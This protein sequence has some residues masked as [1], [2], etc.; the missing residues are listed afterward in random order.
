VR[1]VADQVGT[2][3]CTASLAAVCWA[4]GLRHRTA[5]I[6]HWTDAGVASWYDFAVAIAEDA[7]TAGLLRDKPAVAP[8]AT[9]DYPTPARRPAYSVLDCSATHA[10][11][12]L[13]AVHW[14]AR[15]RTVL[16]EMPHG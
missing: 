15:L 6:F 13:E 11:L 7:F 16:G 3:T 4:L 2:P 14:R 9:R 1:V 12:R 8:I 10:A 5:G